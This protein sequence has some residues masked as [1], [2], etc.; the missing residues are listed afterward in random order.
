MATVYKTSKGK[1]RIIYEGHIYTFKNLTE[2]GEDVYWRCQ[3]RQ[4]PG[5]LKTEAIGVDGAYADPHV[6]L[7]H[8]HPPNQEQV[9]I[10]KGWQLHAFSP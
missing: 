4:Y 2:D 5:S 10:L 3:N 7:D 9:A 6:L 8:Q 1:D